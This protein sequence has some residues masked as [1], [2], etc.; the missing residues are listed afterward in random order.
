[1]QADPRAN[2]TQLLKMA[3]EGDSRATDELLPLV[4]E[5]LRR[6]AR[7]QLVGDAM[8]VTIQ[9]TV[10]VHEAY[11]RLVG[12]GDVSWNNRAHFF[13]A[14]AQAM[15]RI[16]V[17]RARHRGRQ[18]RGG[19]QK[20]IEMDDALLA[21]EPEAETM[22]A[23]DDALRKLEAY[24]PVKG[25]IVMLRF[26]TGLTNEQTAQAMGKSATWVKEEW[27]YARGWLHR[28]LAK[29]ADKD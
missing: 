27:A 28:E 10:L 2:V 13:G 24:D 5:E 15:R 29:Q 16:L 18:K 9:P 21:T 25:Q 17:E 20:R 11:L 19:G 14:A 4:Y 3:G 26:F 8:A 7:A 1:M 23:L 12:D 22:L 6:M